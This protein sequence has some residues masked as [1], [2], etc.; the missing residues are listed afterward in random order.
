MKEEYKFLP[1]YVGSKAYWLKELECFRGENFVELFCG[2]SVISA[3]LA[4]TAILN[5]LDPMIY[6]I[7][8]NFDQ[9]IVPDVFTKDDYLKFR[10]YE[11][12][13]KYVYCL[14]KMSFS[15]V[16]RY[17]KNGFNVP[18]KKVFDSKNIHVKNEYDNALT[19]WKELSP[20]IFNLSYTNVP[21]EYL[22]DKVVVFDPP[23]ENSQ[24]SYNIKFNYD[25]YWNFLEDT[26]KIA[27]SIIIFDTKDN[28]EKHDI[29]IISSRKMRVNGAKQGNVEAM[30][31]FENFEWQKDLRKT[32]NARTKKDNILRLL[33]FGWEKNDI[34]LKFNISDKEIQEI[35]GDEL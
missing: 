4:K 13:W 21:K 23:Y 9:L 18:I 17:S 35:L 33:N 29:N 32:Y 8:T 2:S 15:G 27:K 12:W 25:E 14:Q 6:K 30:G 1:S 26:K 20:L 10:K 31:V 16:F 11:N 19:R 5:D 3:N 22:I 28:L 7:L 24:A 34:I